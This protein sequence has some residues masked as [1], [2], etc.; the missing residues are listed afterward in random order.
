MTDLIRPA[1]FSRSIPFLP[2]AVLT[3]GAALVSCGGGSSSNPACAGGTACGGE[4]AAGRYKIS[5]FCIPSGSMPVEGCAA[6]VTVNTGNISVTGTFT[7]NADKTYQTDT[8]VGGSFAET[9]PS[10]CLTMQG[11]TVSCDQ[12][13]S[14]V[15][16][17]PSASD[18]FSSIQCG[19]GG[20]GCTCTFAL[21]PQHQTAAGTYSTS[22]TTLMLNPT[23][24]GEP[25]SGPYC[26]TPTQVTLLSSMSSL[27]MDMTMPGGMPGMKS[28][29]A[30]GSIVLTKE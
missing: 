27:G 1:R 14:I 9:I 6:G 18:S 22:G 15:N 23:N 29:E 10:S 21:K 26:A 25:D 12:L 28:M 11:V 20:G 30:S 2:L 7:F 13:N 17:D 3:L 4:I 19:G 16:S 24:G 8:T 5:S